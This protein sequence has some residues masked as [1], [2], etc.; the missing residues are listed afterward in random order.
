M[1]SRFFVADHGGR[2]YIHEALDGGDRAWAVLRDA[3]SDRLWGGTPCSDRAKAEEA[4]AR[5][6]QP[7]EGEAVAIV[8]LREV[9]PDEAEDLGAE[10]ARDPEF[11]RQ[12]TRENR[13]RRQEAE[14]AAAAERG[15]GPRM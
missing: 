5:P 2:R 7:F 8:A 12:V 15:N 14:E 9:S 4:F 1:P 13:R 11:F 3:G 10:V 6:P